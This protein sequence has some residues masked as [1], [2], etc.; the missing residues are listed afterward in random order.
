[1]PS[2]DTPKTVR[3]DSCY[4]PQREGKANGVITPGMLLNI[5]N[6]AAIV[7]HNE[8]GQECQAAFAVENDLVG[9]GINDNYAVGEQIRYQI[10]PDGARVYA[11]VA[12]AQ[13]IAIGDLLTSNGDGDLKEAAVTDFVIGIARTALVG[14]GRI[15]LEIA[16][17]RGIA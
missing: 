15:V 2:N 10:L 12:A 5:R 6:Q 13:N 8:A 1:M 11:R 4:A 17:G 14:A 16:K 3:L 7:A 9:K